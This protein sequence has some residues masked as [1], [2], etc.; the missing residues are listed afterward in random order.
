MLVNRDP[1]PRKR[2]LRSATN[3]E[4]EVGL[5]DLASSLSNSNKIPV[6]GAEGGESFLQPLEDS[7]TLET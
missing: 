7:T 2:I 3:K 5:G 6:G 1:N 4:T